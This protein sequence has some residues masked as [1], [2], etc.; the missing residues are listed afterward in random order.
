MSD[1]YGEDEFEADRCC[2]ACGLLLV[3]DEGDEHHCD[4]APIGETMA[5]ALWSALRP[6]LL[7]VEGRAEAIFRLVS[8]PRQE[9][10]WMTIDS[11]HIRSNLGII[12]L[13]RFIEHWEEGQDGTT[14]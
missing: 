11:Q 2:G 13:S 14:P 12:R 8:A 7:A 6:M 1:E 9:V 3:D 10:V 4:L 5:F